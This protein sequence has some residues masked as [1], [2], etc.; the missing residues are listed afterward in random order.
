LDNPTLPG[1]SGGDI[2][3]LGLRSPFR[4]IRDSRGFYWVGDVGGDLFE[5]IN[6]V[7]APAQDFGWSDIEG[8]CP[9]CET[10]GPLLYWDQTP[11]AGYVLDDPHSSPTTARVAWVGP[12]VLAH[13][14]DRYG[15]QLSGSVL[16]GDY[17]AGFV[18]HARVDDG[19]ALQ[20]DAPL[21]HLQNPSSL[22]QHSDGYVYA[23]TFGR[24]ETSKENAGDEPFSRLFRMV[25]KG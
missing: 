25:A 10:E 21:G 3:A 1:V 6:L 7:K 18:R 22:R 13:D 16:F 17:C 4:G 2:Y 12:E 8:P 24:C 20:L 5:E 23:V 15:G 11:S 9:D 14:P 19:G